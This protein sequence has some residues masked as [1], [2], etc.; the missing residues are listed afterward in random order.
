LL[1]LASNFILKI[2]L[3]TYTC[4]HITTKKKQEKERRSYVVT[5]IITPLFARRKNKAEKSRQRK[6]KRKRNEVVMPFNEMR[7]Q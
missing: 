5:K 2:L 6:R 4:T 7:F 1:K 3:N